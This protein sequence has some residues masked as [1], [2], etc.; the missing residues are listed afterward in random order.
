MMSL[1]DIILSRTIVCIL[2]K[3]HYMH[4]HT[5]IVKFLYEIILEFKY[6]IFT[7]H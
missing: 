1:N 2:I 5:W 4:P 6:T 3:W 7:L